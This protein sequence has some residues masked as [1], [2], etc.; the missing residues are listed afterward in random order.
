MHGR[1]VNLT[2]TSLH[3]L[4]AGFYQ[5]KVAT[6]KILVAQTGLTTNILPAPGEL[7]HKLHASHGDGQRHND[8]AVPGQ[9]AFVCSHKVASPAGH[10]HH[11]SHTLQSLVT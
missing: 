7:V 8:I 9:L 6:F 10:I 2:S 5:A 3:T 1:K 11:P 4:L